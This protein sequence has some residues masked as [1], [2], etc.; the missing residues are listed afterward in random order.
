MKF[1]GVENVYAESGVDLG[2]LQSRLQMPC[3]NRVHSNANIICFIHSIKER[4]PSR[5]CDEQD[6]FISD[7]EPLL[8]KLT[9]SGANFVVIGGVAM[10]IHGSAYWTYDV[11]ICYE[12]ID[13]NIGILAKIFAGNSIRGDDRPVDETRLE[14][15]LARANKL[16][17]RTPH[18]NLDFFRRLA[19]IGG[20]EDVCAQSEMVMLFGLPIRVL[21]LDGLIATKRVVGR[22]G[23]QMHVLELDELKKLVEG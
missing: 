11:D 3:S 7:P 9:C 21:S 16:T 20:Y 5:I 12:P 19:G 1:Y 6:Q 8:R 4:P 18:G 15:A 17:L 23:D 13:A 14:T 2:L 10:M 22:I